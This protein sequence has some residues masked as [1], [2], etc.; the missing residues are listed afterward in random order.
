MIQQKQDLVFRCLYCNPALPPQKNMQR[1]ALAVIRITQDAI[2]YKN[3]FEF[4]QMHDRHLNRTA[5]I[6]RRR[7]KNP[8]LVSVGWG[9]YLS[10]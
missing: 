10:Q 6:G 2:P 7:G 5:G 9:H 8:A 4:R 3:N 1:N